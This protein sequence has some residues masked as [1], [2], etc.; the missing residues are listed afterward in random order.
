MEYG[1]L[2]ERFFYVLDLPPKR[3][4]EVQEIRKACYRESGDVSFRMLPPVIFLGERNNKNETI[5]RCPKEAIFEKATIR[6]GRFIV[7]VSGMDDLVESLS[8]PCKQPFLYLGECETEMGK[9]AIGPISHFQLAMLH[10]ETKGETVIWSFKWT[11][12]LWKG[13]ET[14]AD[15]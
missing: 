7:P 15:N 10:I 14:K 5:A 4:E 1:V 6:D 2:M 9:Q 8:L 11:R 13:K 3:K 12:H